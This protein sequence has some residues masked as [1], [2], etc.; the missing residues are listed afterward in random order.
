[1]FDIRLTPEIPI[2]PE[3]GE[4]ASYGILSEWP[5]ERYELQWPEAA[6]RLISGESKSAFVTSFDPPSK[7]ICFVW[8]PCHRI[9]ETVHI[10]NQW[11][12]YEQAPSFAV[13]A[14]YD[15]VAD[16]K[17]VS[18]ADGAAIPEWKLPVESLRDFVSRNVGR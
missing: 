12:F 13:D 3:E 6:Q 4:S 5:P 17:T 7:S 18:E 16:R 1:M 2:E 14:L 9:G 8:C 10:Q 15:C 11:R